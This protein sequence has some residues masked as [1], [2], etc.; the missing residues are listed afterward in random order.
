[1]PARR[2]LLTSPYVGS[3][4]RQD[5]D[6]DQRR[7]DGVRLRGRESSLGGCDGFPEPP[8]A[9]QAA[10][11]CAVAAGRHH[12]GGCDADVTRISRLHHC[13]LLAAKRHEVNVIE[14]ARQHG[15]SPGP[16][17]DFPCS[18]LCRNLIIAV[19]RD[20]MAQLPRGG[21]APSSDKKRRGS[22]IS[23]KSG[24]R[25]WQVWQVLQTRG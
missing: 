3:L 13:D 8:L 16:C 19:V 10:A 15:A 9:A 23:C 21:A 1:M 17:F 22:L 5:G 4:S 11:V 12:D 2:P 6:H 25:M 20:I 18:A 14:R 24:R 7:G